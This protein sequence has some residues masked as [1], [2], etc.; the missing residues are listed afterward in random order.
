MNTSQDLVLSFELAH[1][2]AQVWRALTEPALLERWLMKTDFV[3]ETGH[4]F[5]FRRPA[6]DKWDGVVDCEVLK[7]E[8][9]R[10]ISYTWRA[11]GVDT[12]V[13][14]T[15][16]ETATGTRLTLEQRGFKSD[17]KQ[18]FFGARGG[19]AQM[20]GQALAGLLN[21]IGGR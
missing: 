1:P 8:E 10:F 15:L 17:Q 12:V 5:Q 14:F 21:E 16:A 20:V 19:W 3:L 2:P 7:I 18:A 9:L 6:T 13:S 11:L 4:V